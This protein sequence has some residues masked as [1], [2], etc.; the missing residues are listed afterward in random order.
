MKKGDDGLEEMMKRP[1]IKEEE[2]DGLVM[3]VNKKESYMKQQLDQDVKQIEEQKL[4]L[5]KHNYDKH[6]EMVGVPELTKKWL[7]LVIL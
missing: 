6:E 2:M 3:L 5:E 1:E 7:K 4:C